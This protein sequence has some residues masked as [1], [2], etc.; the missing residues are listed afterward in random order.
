MVPVDIRMTTQET[1]IYVQG[2]IFQSICFLSQDVD[3]IGV[4]KTSPELNF[5]MKVKRN[6]TNYI[7]KICAS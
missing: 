4:R 3:L 1:A 7:Y 6:E 5:W 2:A